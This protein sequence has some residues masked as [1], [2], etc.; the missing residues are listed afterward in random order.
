MLEI[1]DNI[2]LIASIIIV[3]FWV[4]DIIYPPYKNK[5]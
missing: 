5:K 1:T 3:L 2:L 4:I